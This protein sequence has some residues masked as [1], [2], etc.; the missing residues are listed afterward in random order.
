MVT[1][2]RKCVFAILVGGVVFVSFVDSGERHY[3]LVKAF[4]FAWCKLLFF[5]KLS[6]C[7]KLLAVKKM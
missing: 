2:R 1:A 3:M 6:Y 5:F 7:L 4:L